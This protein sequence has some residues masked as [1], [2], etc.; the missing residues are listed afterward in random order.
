MCITQEKS[1]HKIIDVQKVVAAQAE[2]LVIMQA[3]HDAMSKELKSLKRGIL[4]SQTQNIVVNT[5]Q[6]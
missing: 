4:P 3:E 2:M 1:D 5:G 6:R